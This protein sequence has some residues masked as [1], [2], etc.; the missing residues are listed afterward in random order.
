[1][2]KGQVEMKDNWK[3]HSFL[4]FGATRLST[5]MYKGCS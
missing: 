4:F 5:G 2:G 3:G 1:V